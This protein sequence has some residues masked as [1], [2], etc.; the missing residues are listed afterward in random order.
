MSDTEV[1]KPQPGD[2]VQA[3]FHEHS[4][5]MGRAVMSVVPSGLRG[6]MR[7][8]DIEDE[9]QVSMRGG[10]ILP[11]RVIGTG[12]DEDGH[13]VWLEQYQPGDLSEFHKLNASEEEVIGRGT[14][15][16]GA[17]ASPISPSRASDRTAM[18]QGPYIAD[19]HHEDA[20]MGGFRP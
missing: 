4:P 1:R 13:H 2:I 16:H 6:Y 10:Q 5:R 7:W 18:H 3:V 12:T 20:C 15:R 8:I 9:T 19:R 17:S 11:A 14:Y